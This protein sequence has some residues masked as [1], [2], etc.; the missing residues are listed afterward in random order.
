MLPVYFG[1]QEGR[2]Q[3]KGMIEVEGLGWDWIGP[4]KRENK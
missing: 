4:V 3:E 2:G 1:M